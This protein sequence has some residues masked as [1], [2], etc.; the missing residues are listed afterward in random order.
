MTKTQVFVVVG[1][2]TLF[3]LLLFA[4]TIPSKADYPEKEKPAISVNTDWEQA[5]TDAISKLPA[6]WRMKIS[7]W[8]SDFDHANNSQKGMLLDSLTMAWDTLKRIDIASYLVEKKARLLNQSV[9]WMK[10]GEQYYNS[11]S[12]VPAEARTEMYNGAIRCFQTVLVQS[13]KNLDAKAAL[14][15]CYVEGTQDPMKGIGLLREVVLQDSSNLRAQLNLGF[16]SIRSGQFPK[17]I[18]RFKKVLAINPSYIETH[19]YLAEAYEK[20]G[21]KG[22][23]IAQ[24]EAYAHKSSDKEIIKEVQNYINKLKK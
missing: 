4:K 8:R 14:G 20:Q 1:F 5:Q 19:L 24:L 10:A 16:F 23:A 3:V 17:A 6:L 15:A 9:D 18:E 11:V 7:G 2:I 22:N 12:L 13:P 21:D